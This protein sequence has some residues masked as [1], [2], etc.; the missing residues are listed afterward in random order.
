MRLARR[1]TS[2]RMAAHQKSDQ[3]RDGLCA[4]R[5][6]F[7]RN[8]KKC[9]EAIRAGVIYYCSQAFYPKGITNAWLGNAWGGH[10]QISPVIAPNFFLAKLYS[11][12][13][14]AGQ[15]M[16]R[17]SKRHVLRT[18]EGFEVD[19]T[20]DATGKYYSN[21]RTKA[22][23]DS[24]KSQYHRATCEIDIWLEGQLRQ[25]PEE[26]DPVSKKPRPPLS[27]AQSS[28]AASI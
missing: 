27:P 2:D 20:I 25:S 5:L 19:V 15:N 17:Q 14:D 10:L 7:P 18:S 6:L 21:L 9:R 16:D 1:T 8:A 13:K 23:S 4:G 12:G 11:V 28:N 26:N 3:R 22:P 24:T